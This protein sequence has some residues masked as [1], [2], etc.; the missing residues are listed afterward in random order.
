[1]MITRLRALLTAS[2]AAVLIGVPFV[3]VE[4]YAQAPQQAPQQ[5][6]SL[7]VSSAGS[8]NGSNLGALEGADKHSQTLAAAWC[9]GGKM[10]RAYLSTQGAN[11][12]NALHRI[13]K[14]P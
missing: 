9:G 3:L 11:D 12:V 5:P 7:F 2:A 8:G 1:M 4:S 14:G 6:M 10:W 13:G